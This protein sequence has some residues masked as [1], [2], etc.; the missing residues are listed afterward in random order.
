MQ[1]R[2]KRGTS[3]PK[4]DS[5]QLTIRVGNK[6]L[7]VLSSN[8]IFIPVIAYT[9]KHT[10]T[11]IRIFRACPFGAGQDAQAWKGLCSRKCRLT[12]FSTW[13]HPPPYVRTL[14]LPEAMEKLYTFNISNSTTRLAG[15][16]LRLITYSQRDSILSPFWC[17]VTLQDVY[18][19]LITQATINII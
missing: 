1:Y 9:H 8:L 14:P 15:S 4:K 18:K 11:Y 7:C 12:L 13:I 2:K 16:C 17:T 10:H 3:E 19:W 5:S 6:S